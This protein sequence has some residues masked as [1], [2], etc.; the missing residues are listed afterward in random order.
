[1]EGTSGSTRTATRCYLSTPDHAG[2]VYGRSV[3]I[4]TDNGLLEA[5][6]G[7]LQFRGTRT[8]LT[9]EIASITE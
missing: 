9:L 4:Y 7:H 5:T 8:D 6:G 2:T 3:Y 1:M